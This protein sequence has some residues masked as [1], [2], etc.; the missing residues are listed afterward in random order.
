MSQSQFQIQI[1]FGVLVVGLQGDTITDVSIRSRPLL[2]VAFAASPV[3]KRISR[4]VLEYFSDP[5]SPLQWRLQ[6]AGTDYQQRVWKALRAIPVGSVKTYGEL[7][8][9]IGGSARAVGNACRSNPIPVY[10]P[11][12]RVVAKQHIGGFAGKTRGRQIN[13]KRWLLQHEGVAVSV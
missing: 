7:A 2:Q 4:E 1:P 10:I 9:E 5:A 8:A 12:H 13:I 11:C 3:E 6:T